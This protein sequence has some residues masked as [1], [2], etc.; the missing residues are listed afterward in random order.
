MS[1]DM[2]EEQIERNERC[3][4]EM[5]PEFARCYARSARNGHVAVA[6]WARAIKSVIDLVEF[7]SQSAAPQTDSTKE[8]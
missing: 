1:V 2:T 5:L 8:A 6:I 4:K 3:L 7:D